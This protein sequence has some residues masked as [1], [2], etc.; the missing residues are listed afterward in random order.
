MSDEDHAAAKGVNA[1]ASGATRQDAAVA[2]GPSGFDKLPVD[3]L[4]KIAEEVFEGG[5]TGWGAVRDLQSFAATSWKARAG[6]TEFPDLRHID[7]AAAQAVEE[8]RDIWREI[9]NG[10]IPEEPFCDFNAPE[11]FTPPP[12][13]NYIAVAGKLLEHVDRDERLQ[14]VFDV[15]NIT[16]DMTRMEAIEEFTNHFTGLERK[17]QAG[18]LKIVVKTFTHDA[19]E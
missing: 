18:L 17:F 19:W 5:E 13:V 10:G 9:T 6:V 15:I 12:T 14:L 8:G 1:H 16:E 4:G 2:A 3:L 7:E 11:E